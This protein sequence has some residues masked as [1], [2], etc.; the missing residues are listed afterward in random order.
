MMQTLLKNIAYLSGDDL[1]PMRGDILIK[2]GIISGMGEHIIYDAKTTEIV[3]GKH[4]L[5]LPGFVNTHT[6]I[7]MTVLRGYGGDQDLSTWLNKYIW[8]AEARLT[9]D[10]VYWGSALALL[11]MTAAGVTTIADMYDHMDSVAK[12]VSE[13]GLR[14]NLCRGMIGFFDD[15][16]HSLREN[17]ELF[18]RW[19]GAEKGRIRVWYGPHATNTCDPDYLQEVA[20]RAREKGS[21]IHIHVAETKAEFEDI[22]KKFGKTPVAL[23]ADCGLFDGPAIIAHGVWLTDDDITLLKKYHVS[24]AHN[25]ASNMKLA[26]GQ[27]RVVDLR[28]AGVP[29]GIGTDGASSNNRLSVLHDA[30]LAALMHKLR[31]LD[32]TAVSAKDALTMATIEGARALQWSEDIGSLAPGKAADIVCFNMDKPWLVPNFDPISTIIYAARSDDVSRVY[33]SGELLYKNGEW[34]KLD[35]ER[36]CFEANA[37]AKRII[38]P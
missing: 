25:P 23:A 15:D 31:D 26:S 12:I 16:R 14:A 20:A 33:A 28:Q 21:G 18:E 29:V 1:I 8:P 27:A 19:H 6:H 2:D 10:D 30:Q 9:D 36:I 11:E 4:L 37:V 5:A 3:D 35:A 32:P 24:V 34:I 38:Q 22:Q 17:D 7:A 13:S